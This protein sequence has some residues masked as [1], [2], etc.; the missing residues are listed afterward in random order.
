MNRLKW[1]EFHKKFTNSEIWFSKDIEKFI[2]KTRY[3]F[4]K[5]YRKEYD[6]YTRKNNL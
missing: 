1:E 6:E 5:E 4:Y 3:K 2:G